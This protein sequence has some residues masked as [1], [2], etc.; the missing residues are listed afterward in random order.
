MN[1]PI[2]SPLFLLGLSFFT[3]NDTIHA[4][5]SSEFLNSKPLIVQD[6]TR[7]IAYCLN[8]IEVSL[9]VTK[10]VTI[11]AKDLNVGSYDNVTSASDLK[12]YFDGDPSKQSVTRSC[13]DFVAIGRGNNLDITI[14][15]WV[16]DEAGNA[17]H[18][19]TTVS[20]ND[21]NNVCPSE[22]GGNTLFYISG[23]I[24]SNISSTHIG[25]E[26]HGKISLNGTN[27]FHSETFNNPYKFSNLANGNYTLCV[28]QKDGFLNGISTAD[29]VKIKRHI[30]GLELLESPYKLLASD[31]NRSRN[32]TAADVSELKKIILGINSTLTK[33]PSWIFIPADFIF[34]PNEFPDINLFIPSC[35]TIEIKDKSLDKVDFIGIKMG[36]VN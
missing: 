21:N 1:K 36:N 25:D 19:R 35:K 17:A 28:E 30:L 9:P 3:F 24:S 10:S 34:P 31:L 20:I 12:F 18:C 8:F 2:T 5:G 6:T 16:E 27:G 13:E 4:K 7:P 14:A 22:P 32:L 33:V 11:Y 29:I 26:F 15:M 23:N